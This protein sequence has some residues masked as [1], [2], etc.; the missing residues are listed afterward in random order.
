MRYS[1]GR[2]AAPK[3]FPAVRRHEAVEG[4]LDQRG[5]RVDRGREQRVATPEGNAGGCDRTRRDRD[6]AAVAPGVE[7][8]ELDR[9]RDREQGR[10][11]DVDPEG[12]HRADVRAH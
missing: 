4:R 7:Q 9:A 3:R 5:N 10:K 8:R 12:V 1:I 6:R 2:Y 11:R